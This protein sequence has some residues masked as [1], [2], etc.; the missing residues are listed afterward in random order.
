MQAGSRTILKLRHLSLI[1]FSFVSLLLQKYE[2]KKWDSDQKWAHIGSV[3]VITAHKMLRRWYS[4]MWVFISK[5]IGEV[6]LEIYPILWSI[7]TLV[8]LQIKI[9][10]MLMFWVPQESYLMWV[11]NQYFFCSLVKLN[12]HMKQQRTHLIVMSIITCCVL[13]HF[14][15]DSQ[16]TYEMYFFLQEIVYPIYFVGILAMIK[17]FLPL[18]PLPAIPSF[19]LVRPENFT[20]EYTDK[21]LVCPNDSLTQAI[22]G[23]AAGIF[24]QIMGLNA[25]PS[26]EFYPDDVKM[27]AAFQEKY[28]QIKGYL[29]FNN[30]SYI[31]L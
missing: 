14:L 9:Y 31:S 10:F 7:Y 24:K 11:I 5:V 15:I 20:L 21:I 1:W 25:T 27:V 16:L 2:L 23:D 8:Q 18:D 28:S 6:L 17:A 29:S 30:Y 13:I 19:P 26:L 12:T 22:A 4:I 3:L